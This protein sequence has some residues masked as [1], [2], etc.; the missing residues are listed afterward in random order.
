MRARVFGKEQDE[1][2]IGSP[3][4]FVRPIAG[5]W[6][7]PAELVVPAALGIVM[8]RLLFW[9]S[10]LAVLAYTMVVAGATIAV[11]FYVAHQKTANNTRI[12]PVTSSAMCQSFQFDTGEGLA[13]HGSSLS[14]GKPA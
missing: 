2:L 4:R 13:R 7:I 3:G 11:G 12:E 9:R 1:W 14:L 10:L 6:C 5:D 8:L